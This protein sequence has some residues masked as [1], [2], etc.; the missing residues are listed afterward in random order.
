MGYSSRSLVAECPW[1][2]YTQEEDPSSLPWRIQEPP[3]TTLFPI[4][5]HFRLWGTPSKYLPFS[6]TL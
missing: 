1:D 6:L 4:L 3:S 5:G 2:G